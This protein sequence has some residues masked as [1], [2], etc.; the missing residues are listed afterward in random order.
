MKMSELEEG[1]L[2]CMEHNRLTS[3][4]ACAYPKLKLKQGYI[5]IRDEITPK[6]PPDWNVEVLKEQEVYT[7]FNIR[8][9]MP[10]QHIKDLLD[11]LKGEADERS[12]SE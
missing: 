10:L 7:D 1:T 3:T 11:R 2:F 5:D 4:G 8:F 6:N 9:G 12:E